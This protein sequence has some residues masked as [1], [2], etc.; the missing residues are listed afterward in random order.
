LGTAF[1]KT[2]AQRLASSGAFFFVQF[3]VAILVKFLGDRFAIKTAASAAHLSLFPF[4]SISP[5]GF[6]MLAQHGTFLFAQFAVAVF[7]ELLAKRFTIDTAAALRAWPAFSPLCAEA[8][9]TFV[10]GLNNRNAA[11]G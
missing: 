10:L 11:K 6:Q 3:S 2:L 1:F 9:A 4:R 7:V 8:V 5:Q